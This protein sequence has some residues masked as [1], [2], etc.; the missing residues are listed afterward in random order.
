MWIL[1]IPFKN[2]IF[3]YECIFVF[4]VKTFIEY[5]KYKSLKS[6]FTDFTTDVLSNL[7]KN[8][9]YY[10]NSKIEIFNKNFYF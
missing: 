7:C 9:L 1:S 6:Y 10:N 4:K 3:I 8:E 2:I 5:F